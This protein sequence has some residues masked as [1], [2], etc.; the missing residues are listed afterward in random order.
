MNELTK[1]WEC[2]PRSGIPNIF[3][4]AQFLTFHNKKYIYKLQFYIVICSN[5]LMPLYHYMGSTYKRNKNFCK[6]K[7]EG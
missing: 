3:P 1:A 2:V 7:K 6:K 5:I 4:A